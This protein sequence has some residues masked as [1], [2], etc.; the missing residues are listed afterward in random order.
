[1]SEDEPRVIY[2]SSLLFSKPPVEAME[3][4]KIRHAQ[5]NEINKSMASFFADY[6]RLRVQYLNELGKVL[7]RGETL[8]SGPKFQNDKVEALG[9][10]NPLWHSVLKQLVDEFDSVQ[11]NNDVLASQVVHPLKGYAKQYDSNLVEMDDLTTLASQM[12]TLEASGSQGTE[13][14]GLKNEWESRAP[15]FFEI[16]ETYDFNRIV[17]L[18]N[19]LLKYQTDVNDSLDQ[20][21]KLNET[22]LELVLNLNPA[23]EIARFSEAAGKQ[24][25]DVPQPK[26]RIVSTSSESTTPG[27]KHRSSHIFPHRKNRD[28]VV[29]TPTKHS[30][31]PIA[32]TPSSAASAR[33]NHSIQT[34]R[35][36][37]SPSK[38]KTK[39]RSKVGSIFGR[40]KDK[41]R[42]TS[43][44]E[45]LGSESSS[46]VSGSRNAS[47][48]SLGRSAAAPPVPSKETEAAT[49]PPAIA[50]DPVAPVSSAAPQAVAESEPDTASSQPV[51]TFTPMQ[52][53]KRASSV[54]SSE[55]LASAPASI[56]APASVG[57]P[58]PISTTGHT[59]VA[60]PPPA[61][62]KHG[63]A[64]SVSGS[65]PFGSPEQIRTVPH[66]ATAP[67]PPT[68]RQSMVFA[69]GSASGS[70]SGLTPPFRAAS[71]VSHSYN[72]EAALTPQG[73]G[74][75]S[76]MSNQTGGLLSNG[77]IHHPQL[78]Y[79]G[80]NA[81]VVELF[82]A[83][84][85]NGVLQ[86][87]N[88][89]GEIAFSFIVSENVSPPKSIL[90]QL[91]S[92]SAGAPN[93]FLVNDTFLKQN[94]ESSFT[95]TDPKQIVL[96]AIGGLK[97]VLN[98]PQPPISIQQI[99][100]YEP[101]QASAVILVKISPEVASRMGPEDS[102][103]LSNFVI[104]LSIAGAP[105][106]S[107]AT[108]PPASFNREKARVTW[109]LSSSPLVLKVGQ[110]EKFT[111]RFM[112]AG[113]AHESDSGCQVRFTINNDDG[114]HFVDSGFTIQQQA[115]LDS[116][117]DPFSSTENVGEWTY[118]PTLKTVVAGAYSGHS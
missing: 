65:E 46:L 19:A 57:A 23:D 44:L 37:L 107:A 87:A 49:A 73:T 6:G 18:K 2:S 7:K 84:Y 106:S 56:P 40:K 66:A 90:L 82:N 69:N 60:P 47:T 112:T 10:L 78:T 111:V 35:S 52:V 24:T 5:L 117:E 50:A 16:F 43:S 99:W 68:Q 29:A 100:R 95:I 61:A 116:E 27:H 11:K 36:D 86:R 58:T 54:K 80:L 15:Y 71:V 115:V 92:L 93:S 22:A 103:V 25:F 114:V 14:Q 38:Q 85:K 98:T 39:L 105:A 74:A 96:R 64:S 20:K 63:G 31:P 109:N 26:E 101:H 62:R 33:D 13:L 88:V 30:A 59:V 89:V 118:I 108:K 97:Y 32:H 91:G 41:K 21:K 9:L 113:Q 17:F 72:G 110:E 4:L 94:S 8:F 75:M 28:S 45:P 104:A 3:V 83:S 53:T 55:L 12:S 70:A 34:E 42:V 1:M 79:P 76:I 77:Q 48:L 102:L 51:S 67:P 81:S